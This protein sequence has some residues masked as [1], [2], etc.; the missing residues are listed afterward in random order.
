MTI[1]DL[2]CY[3]VIGI[4]VALWIVLFITMKRDKRKYE[5]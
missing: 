1:E 3:L 4:S 2:F 5:K